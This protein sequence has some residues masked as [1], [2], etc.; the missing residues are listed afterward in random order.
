MISDNI[1]RILRAGFHS[2]FKIPLL[3]EEIKKN[4]AGELV[5][6][7]TL[8]EHYNYSVNTIQKLKESTVLIP[9]SKV[10]KSSNGVSLLYS[11]I[12]EENHVNSIVIDYHFE[13]L[14]YLLSPYSSGLTSKQVFNLLRSSTLSIRRA[15][16]ILG[17]SR[18]KVETVVKVCGICGRNM[19]SVTEYGLCSGCKIV[20]DTYHTYRRG[21]FKVPLNAF[22]IPNFK[23]TNDIP[24][25]FRLKDYEIH[26]E[27]YSLVYKPAP[28]LGESY[29]PYLP[30][31]EFARKITVL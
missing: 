4:P 3:Q 25:T 18:N 17:L 1:L 29:R 6:I 27:G 19:S 2:H 26:K 31:E 14:T 23:E 9:S 7:L 12:F 16:Y 11:S 20:V 10:P 5:A 24:V 22:N 28:L 13:Q 30:I 15:E 8:A 21:V